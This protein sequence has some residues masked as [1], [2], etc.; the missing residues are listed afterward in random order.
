MVCTKV[1]QVLSWK[2]TGLCRTA[3]VVYALGKI[4]PFSEW[5]VKGCHLGFSIR[6]CAF[7]KVKIALSVSIISVETKSKGSYLTYTPARCGAP[8]EKVLDIHNLSGN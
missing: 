5:H 6:N 2:V 8:S 7:L 1:G 3:R 4:V